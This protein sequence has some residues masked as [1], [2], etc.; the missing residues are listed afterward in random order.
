MTQGQQTNS[1]CGQAANAARAI[2]IDPAAITAIHY[3]WARD[4]AAPAIE[5]LAAQLIRE[6]L[7]GN[8]SMDEV[9]SLIVETIRRHQGALGTPIANALFSRSGF[10][11]SLVRDSQAAS[12]NPPGRFRETASEVREANRERARQGKWHVMSMFTFLVCMCILGFAVS[13]TLAGGMDDYLSGVLSPGDWR[14]V[15]QAFPT[16]RLVLDGGFLVSI[17]G[18]A[19]GSYA[20][21]ANNIASVRNRLALD[22]HAHFAELYRPVLLWTLRLS[23]GFAV[24]MRL[25]AILAIALVFLGVVH[26]SPVV[27]GLVALCSV[28]TVGGRDV[29]ARMATTVNSELRPLLLYE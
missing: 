26:P 10:L 8:S 22:K 6:A 9:E 16:I 11:W 19:A 14:A 24:A 20:G 27:G 28:L 21:V 18:A 3:L 13:W 17:F 5:A 25:S 1:G 4:R 23:E 7:R 29:F 15:S 12:T 2:A